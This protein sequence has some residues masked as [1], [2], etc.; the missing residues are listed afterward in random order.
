[1]GVIVYRFC[2]CYH[3]REWQGVLLIKK[4][5]SAQFMLCKSL[6]STKCNH[7]GDFMND[8]FN[9]L[10]VQKVPN[11]QKSHK[12]PIATFPTLDRETHYHAQ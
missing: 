11:C 5:I 10:I 12:K 1:M 8:K 4:I 7:C 2:M 3:T 9:K 6:I